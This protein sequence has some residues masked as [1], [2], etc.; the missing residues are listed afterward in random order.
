[1]PL[2]CT[3]AVVRASVR[4]RSRNVWSWVSSDLSTFTATVRCSTVSSARQTSPMP[5]TAMRR[6]SRYRSPSRVSWARESTSP[7]PRPDDSG[8]DLL[9]DRGRRPAAG[10]LA[11][12]VAAVLDD[13]RDGDLAAVL[14]GE[15]DEPGVRLP[16]GAVLGGAGLAGD[17]HAADLRGRAG[18]AG[19]HAAHHPGQPV[20]D[21]RA[22]RRGQLL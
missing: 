18:A 13:D 2:C 17:V 5:P 22:H 8:H 7:A 21:L 15:P 1:M 6:A 4:N 9:R 14:L 20:G 19:D 11:A 12:P 10:D 16:V 3:D